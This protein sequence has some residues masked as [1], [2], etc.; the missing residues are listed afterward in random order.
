MFS[1]RQLD[2]QNRSC[3]PTR[4]PNRTITPW[5][6]REQNQKLLAN[7]SNDYTQFFLLL[8]W[9]PLGIWAVVFSFC[10]ERAWPK[11]RRHLG[12]KTHCVKGFLHLVSQN[13]GWQGCHLPQSGLHGEHSEKWIIP[14]VSESVLCSRAGP[15]MKQ[16]DV[17]G[18]LAGSCAAPGSGLREAQGSSLGSQPGAAVCS[19]PLG[20]STAPEKRPPRRWEGA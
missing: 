6:R 20:P 2:S 1:Y 4:E 16:Q 8:R 14:Y 15:S 19:S 7:S 9:R 17:Q 11:Q 18:C 3:G 10:P 5:A 13:D 12:V